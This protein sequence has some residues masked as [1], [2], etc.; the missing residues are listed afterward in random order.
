MRFGVAE[1]LAVAAVA[2]AGPAAAHLANLDEAL[3]TTPIT[4]QKL[5]DDVYV[6]SGVGGNIVV[7]IG[8]DAATIHSIDWRAATSLEYAPTPAF[9]GRRFSRGDVAQLVRA[10]DP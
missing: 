10:A 8:C 6:L 7:S 9:L 4:T 3:C 5:A 2:M 1:R